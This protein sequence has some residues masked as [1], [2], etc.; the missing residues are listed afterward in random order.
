MLRWMKRLA[1]KDF[2]RR[3]IPNGAIRGLAW[4]PN[5]HRHN[6]NPGLQGQF[7]GTIKAAQKA[8]R[9]SVGGAFRENTDRSAAA[10]RLGGPV[11]SRPAAL[12]QRTEN[13]QKRRSGRL[14]HQQDGFSRPE[15]GRQA[16]NQGKIP[17]GDEADEFPAA[18][19]GEKDGEQQGFEPG[20]VVDHHNERVL[21]RAQV[22]DA[23][24]VEDVAAQKGID[25]PEQEPA[26]SPRE[27]GKRAAPDFR[28]PRREP[29]F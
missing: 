23:M 28:Q 6:G 27:K 5:P 26:E 4:K 18:L 20:A 3:S 14:A 11:E 25:G 16:R 21:R 8:A 17:I 15:N 29:C 19:E 2:H 10:Q 12:E 22:F 24:D 13:I 9:V 1:N 7:G